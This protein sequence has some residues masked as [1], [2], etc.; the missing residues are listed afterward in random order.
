M[1]AA[2]SI[3]A[4]I[5]TRT[6]SYEVFDLLEALAQQTVPPAEI[7]VIDSGSSAEV[8][9]RLAA[10]AQGGAPPLRLL[11]MRP[12]EY[13]SARA[14]NRAIET[15]RAD[16]VA[17]ISQDALPADDRYLERLS[18]ALADPRIAGAYAR[19]VP[20]PGADPLL[21]KDLLRTYPPQARTQT[22]PDCWFVNT[23]SVIRRALWERHPFQEE[24]N[25]SEDHE[26]ARWA[27]SDGHAIRYCADAVVRHGHAHR[28][29]R[30]LWRRHFEEGRGLCVVHGRRPGLVAA[31]LA[32]GREFAS[33]ALWL[34]RRGRLGWIPV[35]LWRRAVKHAALWAGHRREARARAIRGRW[36]VGRW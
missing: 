3:A 27:E 20:G 18:G 8:L 30:P 5:R 12:E 35:S 10:R 25:I 33:D 32:W 26:W 2:A 16:L 36:P 19:Q 6:E 28:G 31:L 29:A 34:A 21:E 1:T 24:A 14:L 22:A 7:V 9:R 23:C 13:Q 11:T 4:V 15:T 17:I